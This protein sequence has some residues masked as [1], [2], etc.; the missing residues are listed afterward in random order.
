MIISIFFV[1][2]GIINGQS[3][4]SPTSGTYSL[5]TSNQ[6]ANGFS[7]S[8]FN[9]GDNLLI[10]IGL[11]NH[12][13]GTNLRLNSTTGLEASVGYNL[14]E[15]FT[16]ISFTGNQTNVNSALSSLQVNTGATPGTINI[17][18]SATVNPPGYYYLPTNGHFYKPVAWPTGLSGG[19][20]VYTTIKN[21]AASETFKGQ[22]GYLVTITSQDEQDFIHAN[23]PINNILIAL[24]DE[25]E[26]GIWKWDA[27]P[28]AGHV[29]GPFIN[30]CGGEPN[31]AGPGENYAVTNWNDGNCWNDYGPP[32]HTFSSALMGGWIV[33]FGTWAD[34]A[35][36]TFTEFYS[37]SVSHQSYPP[38]PTSIT[39]T[40]STICSG[41]STQL[42]ANGIQGTVYWYTGSCGG[43]Q[44]NTGN[45]ITVSPTTTTIYYA[46]NYENGQYSIGCASIEVIVNPL[47]QYRSKQSGNWTTFANWEQYNGS[48]W[49]DATSYPGEI[50]NDCNNPQVTIL[51]GNQME[52]QTGTNI[53]IPNLEIKSSGKVT[54]KSRGKLTVN[55]ILQLDKSSGA[56]I[57]IE[58]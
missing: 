3:V 50:S 6:A 16:R 27:G 56:S 11:I 31:N 14:S 5:N 23:V 1:V 51:D 22:N 33:E 10:S 42:N 57:I 36:Q 48:S 7:V 13:S 21:D 28:E 44:I 4:L 34:P 41:N 54:I 39:A 35:N 12:P 25:D 8:G 19:A 58:Q 47:I 45:S 17:T 55:D 18:V 52:I 9:E 53:N 2:H 29:V 43:V 26:E 30:W 20:E 15:N 32:Q 24:T 40:N 38:I 49:V 37:G 46:R